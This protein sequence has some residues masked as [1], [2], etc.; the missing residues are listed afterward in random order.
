MPMDNS[1]RTSPTNVE[2]FSSEYFK[3]VEAWV[4]NG[5]QWLTVVKSDHLQKW[6]VLLL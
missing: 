6:I 4:V 1:E 2:F 3:V 5:G